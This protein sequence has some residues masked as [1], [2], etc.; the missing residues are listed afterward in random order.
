MAVL[1]VE[2]P[3]AVDVDHDDAD[4]PVA[5]A[6][7]LELELSDLLEPA[8]VEQPGVGVG[9]GRVREA[10][11]QPPHAHAHRRRPSTCASAT[12]ASVPSHIS[13]AP[14][15]PHTTSAVGGGDQRDLAGRPPAVQEV[16]GLEADGDVEDR[17]DALPGIAEELDRVGDED[18]RQ[19]ERRGRGPAS[20]AGPRREGRAGR[21]RRRAR[22]ARGS[23]SRSSRAEFGTSVRTSAT[24][25]PTTNA[26][27][28][29][30]ASARRT[31][32]GVVRS[33]GRLR[34]PQLVG[35]RGGGAIRLHTRG[36]RRTRE[37]R[38]N[39]RSG[40][41]TRPKSAQQTA[42]D[43]AQ[44]RL[45]VRVRAVRRR[46]NRDR[47]AVAARVEAARPGGPTA[48]F[49]EPQPPLKYSSQPRGA[50]RP[51]P[52]RCDGTIEWSRRRARPP[53]AFRDEV[54]EPEEE[55]RLVGGVDERV[56]PR[57]R[58]RR[59]P[60]A[61]PTRRASRRRPRLPTM[62]RM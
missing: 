48:P 61:C 56:R 55:A 11:D 22:P 31:R 20:A 23:R 33:L 38:F 35:S 7:A 45:A 34:T 28:S 19:R 18:R 32:Q 2:L 53:V 58:D 52:H 12:V 21:R 9:A 57:V 40:Y 8:P 50:T 44:R 30:R 43:P 1:L 14:S 37:A 5:A 25:A 6:R 4:R 29:E 26:Y 17:P 47:D 59:E 13:S 46:H 27:P 49:P 51:T 3:E 16:A 15:W 60:C 42:E 24:V 54:V 10:R 41:W 39:P 62:F 36:Y